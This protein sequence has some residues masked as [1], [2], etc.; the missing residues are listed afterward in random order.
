M[1]IALVEIAARLSGEA[2]IAAEWCGDPSA[3]VS[4]VASLTDA[5]PADLSFYADRRYRDAARTTQA[6][7]IV[8]ARDLAAE[9]APERRIVVD[10]P[11][12]ALWHVLT[13]F[14]PE[15]LHTRA[16]SEPTAPIAP[17]AEVAPTA[18]V[19]A[20]A[21]VGARTRIGPG[22]RI[23]AGARIGD[24]VTIDG[25]SEI[26]PNAVVLDGVSIGARVRIGAASVIGSVGFGFAVIDGRRRRMPHLGTV[27]IEDDVEIGANCTVDR[28]LLGTTRIGRG[29]KLDDLV[30]VG[31]NVTIGAGV[32]VAAQ[33]GFAGSATIGDG[34][35]FG[36]QS[37][38][39]DHVTVAPGSRVGAKAGVMKSLGGTVAGHPARPLMEQRRAEATARRLDASARRVEEMART[40][41]DLVRRVAHLERFMGPPSR[42]GGE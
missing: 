41:D 27:V 42:T 11:R 30:H 32:L 5:T 7:A 37:G 25:E 26:E 12:A 33:V 20:S 3:A 6:R 29:S 31:H 13:W 8:V 4:G 34:A 23:G 1:Q 35:V 21:T 17:D 36:G 14:S 2:G 9:I 18:E 24:D 22:V 15:A 39:A 40:L 10:D 28:A 38:V 19:A 16:G